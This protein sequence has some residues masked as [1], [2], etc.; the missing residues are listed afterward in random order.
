MALSILRATDVSMSNL[1]MQYLNYPT[2]TLV[3]SSRVAFTVITGQVFLGKRYNTLDYFVVLFIILGLSMFLHADSTSSDVI[4]HPL[5]V[6]FLVSYLF[7][8]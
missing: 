5:G 8:F 2:K 1:S 3:K 6:A 4:F 7:A